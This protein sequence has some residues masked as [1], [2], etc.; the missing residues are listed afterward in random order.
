V[1]KCGFKIQY[2]LYPFDIVAMLLP[3]LLLLLLLVEL[4]MFHSTVV[5]TVDVVNGNS[6]AAHRVQK[7]SSTSVRKERDRF[8][9]YS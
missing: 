5:D 9:I 8:D 3:L 2:L 7:I 6:P 4:L 1:D